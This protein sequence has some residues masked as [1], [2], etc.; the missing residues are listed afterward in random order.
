MELR[1]FLDG[2][3]MTVPEFT[4]M[5]GGSVSPDKET[6]PP[7]AAPVASGAAPAVATGSMYGYGG[8]PLY[9]AIAPYTPGM[10]PPNHPLTRSGSQ[11]THPLS[12]HTRLHLK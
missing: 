3:G 5:R 4:S 11:N 10:M 1:Q 2:K 7:T 12:F 8:A 6:A 9:P